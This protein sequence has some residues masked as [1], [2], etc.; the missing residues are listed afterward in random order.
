[1]SKFQNHL[2]K[3]NKKALLRRKMVNQ[4]GVTKTVAVALIVTTMVMLELNLNT[5]ILLPRLTS[6]IEMLELSL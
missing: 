2:L 4:V 5:M 1:V 3:M 6:S